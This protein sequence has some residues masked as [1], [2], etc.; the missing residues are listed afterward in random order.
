VRQDVVVCEGIDHG[1]WG[2][3]WSCKFEEF[4]VL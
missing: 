2:A 3:N 1:A 4:K